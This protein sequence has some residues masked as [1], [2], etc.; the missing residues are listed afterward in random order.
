M[1]RSMSRSV[2]VIACAVAMLASSCS[3]FR[4][5]PDVEVQAVPVS[6]V[7]GAKVPSP[8]PQP[9]V[10]IDEPTLPPIDIPPPVET[11]P[12]PGRCDEDPYQEGCPGFI[13]CPPGN[14]MNAAP[15]APTDVYPGKNEPVLG[16]YLYS[17]FGNFSGQPEELVITFNDID[18]RDASGEN[19]YNYQF[20][21]NYNNVVLRFE[22]QPSRDPDQDED[23]ADAGDPGLFLRAI[24]IPP[25]D[26]DGRRYVFGPARPVKLMS[27]PINAGDVIDDAQQE[28]SNKRLIGTDP[29]SARS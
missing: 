11:P 2:A 4:G 10:G 21:N 19:G 12:P 3:V 25:K 9:T 6:L 8:S 23:P 15:A 13:L 14:A 20:V 27:F 18:N 5:K 28:F 1:K 22:V 24:E 29:N 7:F 16:K 17:H 26:S